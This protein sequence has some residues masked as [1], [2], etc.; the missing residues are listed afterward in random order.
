MTKGRRTRKMVQNFPVKYL[1]C[2]LPGR[3]RVGWERKLGKEDA[4]GALVGKI[5]TLVVGQGKYWD[6]CAWVKP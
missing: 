5:R 4:F 6:N 3:G 2:T 1:R